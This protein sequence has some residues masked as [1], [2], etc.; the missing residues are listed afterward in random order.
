MNLRF[1]LPLLLLTLSLARF[2]RAQQP[3]AF[4]AP[5]VRAMAT[6]YYSAYEYRRI[7]DRA[8]LTPEQAYFD[9]AWQ[10]GTLLTADGRKVPV[11]ALRYNMALRLVE[12]RDAEAASGLSIL[13]P[14]S[15]Q[16][17]VLGPEGKPGSHTFVARAEAHAANVRLFL[18]LL[19]VGPLQLLLLHKVDEH[20]SNWSAVNNVETRTSS[21]GRSA[22]LF[23]GAADRPTVTTLLPKRKSVEKLFGPQAPQVAEYAAR[24]NLSYEQVPDLVWMVDYFNQLPRPGQP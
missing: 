15:I 3:A 1:S 20:D 22:L 5:E 14:G 21:V 4:S 7:I 6:G 9:P 24:Q 17:F 16:G 11:P 10:A 8:A 18:E 23:V 2:G 12:V 13:P 19:N